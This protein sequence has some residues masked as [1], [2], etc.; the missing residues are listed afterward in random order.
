LCEFLC[1]CV[2]KQHRLISH[3]QELQ[4][5]ASHLIV[6][7]SCHCWGYRPWSAYMSQRHCLLVHACHQVFYES[8]IGHVCKPGVPFVDERRAVLLIP[9]NVNPQISLRDEGGGEKPLHTTEIQH[10][11]QYQ[12][13]L[14]KLW[15]GVTMSSTNSF[16]HFNS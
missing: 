15:F 12:G 7:Y 3:C 11:S 2:L 1:E 10:C 16:L 5:Q 6:A 8:G 13:W 9:L 4:F 14:G